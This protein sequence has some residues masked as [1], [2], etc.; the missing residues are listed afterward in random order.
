VHLSGKADARDAIGGD[1]ALRQDRGH[2]LS[3]GA[4][5]V[6]GILFRPGGLR[7]T[8]DGV[9]GRRRCEPAAIVVEKQRARPARADVDA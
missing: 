3:T 4:P 1:T 6:V 5:P 9:V 8:K 2:R 7:R